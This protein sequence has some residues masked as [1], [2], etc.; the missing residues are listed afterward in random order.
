MELQSG[1]NDQPMTKLIQLGTM[2][3]LAVGSMGFLQGRGMRWREANVDINGKFPM[4]GHN[5]QLAPRSAE[6]K[7]STT[8]CL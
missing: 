6:F 7:I 3:R 4:N 5:R 8:R 2:D 1:I